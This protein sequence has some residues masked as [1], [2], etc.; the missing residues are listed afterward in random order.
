MVAPSTKF[1]INNAPGSKGLGRAQIFI[2]CVGVALSCAAYLFLNNFTKEMIQAKNE[3]AIVLTEQQLRNDLSDFKPTL[4]IAALVSDKVIYEQTK[5][6]KDQLIYSV[7]DLPMF[8]QLLLFKSN[9]GD[10]WQAYK[11]FSQPDL[12]QNRPFQSTSNENLIAFV[13][14]YISGNPNFDY[15]VMTDVPGGLEYQEQS[16]PFI[17][18]PPVI[19]LH[20]TKNARNET[21]I[22]AGV[23]SLHN[24]LRKSWV[25]QNIDVARIQIQD[26]ESG[27]RLYVLARGATEF[28]APRAAGRDFSFEISMGDKQ[29]Q[30][31]IRLQMD[32]QSTILKDFP[33]F[34]FFLGLMLTLLTVVYMRKNRHQAAH[35]A[36]MNKMLTQKNYELNSEI[37]EREKL[38]NSLKKAEREYRAIIDAVSDVIFEADINGKLMF[39]NDTWEKVTKIKVSDAIGKDIFVMVLPQ[40]RDEQRRMFEDLIAGKTSAYN[41]ITKLKTADGLYRS[42]EMRVSMMRQDQNKNTRVIGTLTDVEERQRTEKALNE[43]EEKYRTIVENAAGGIYQITTDGM[44]LSANPAMAKILGF[45]NMDS[46]LA[47]PEYSHMKIYTSAQDHARY[48]RELQTFGA[49]QN[50]ETMVVRK[51]GERIW[52]NEN[53]RAV[54]DNAGHVLYYEGSMEDITSRKKAE[55]NLKEA[56]IQ[57]D[58]ANR[59]KSEF[60]AN[61]SHE[62]RTPLN[63]IIG[64]AEIIKNEMLGPVEN[65]QYWEY[66][67]DIHEGGC[68]LLKIIN[69]ILDL[70]RIEVGERQLRDDVVDVKDV[71]EAALNFLAPRFERGQLTIKNRLENHNVLII[72]E[73]QAFKQI[74]LNILSNAMNFT[75]EGGRVTISAELDGKDQLRISITDTGIGMDKADIEKAITPFGQLEAGF[76]KTRGGAGLGLTIVNA[77]VGLHKGKLDIV[78]QKNVGTTVSVILPAQRVKLFE[79]IQ[80]EA[81]TQNAEPQKDESV[82]DVRDESLPKDS[83]HDDGKGSIH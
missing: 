75:P 31:N 73:E 54:Q 16:D 49:L 67:K 58:V 29:W 65:R 57:S 47:H 19:L 23:T 26:K 70:S 28:D 45:E 39:L 46:L 22:I 62:L 5:R 17:S 21:L 30:S 44:F 69:E 53:A 61:I 18:A 36:S 76:D 24:I 14:S 33:V 37:N 13:Q 78:S 27:R 59:A 83:I 12:A 68:N 52:V 48:E 71:I 38:N 11:I 79:T 8:N 42:F 63:S 72:G 2:A 7:P 56:K 40:M 50:F 1:N 4:Q 82:V 15:A 74:M 66:A 60:L 9:N 51:N 41:V 77:L 43:A 35:T 20:R 25:T 32:R 64:F 3:Q 6:A 80:A 81:I 34:I 10:V 55:L